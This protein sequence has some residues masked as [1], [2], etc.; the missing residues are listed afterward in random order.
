MPLHHDVP[1]RPA[2]PVLGRQNLL[3]GKV[4]NEIKVDDNTRKWALVALDRMLAIKGTG[5][6]T[7]KNQPIGTTM[8]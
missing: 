4:V 1:N 6:P 5:N 7:K 2:A 3:E 8:D